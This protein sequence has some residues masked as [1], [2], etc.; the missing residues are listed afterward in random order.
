MSSQPPP[1]PPNPVSARAEVPEYDPKD[2]MGIVKY[3]RALT[4][5]QG[6]PD[7]LADPPP[8]PASAPPP[9]SANTRK[10]AILPPPPPPPCARVGC[11]NLGS[12]NK[13]C[14]KCLVACY[15]CVECQREDWP[16]H[17]KQCKVNRKFELNKQ[18]EEDAREGD[19][20]DPS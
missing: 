17:R 9:P 16:A 2:P 1:Q 6:G 4:I 5:A 13:R 3:C 15:C 10:P 14:S 18:T 11:D 19:G 20:Q 7:P 12:L 8:T